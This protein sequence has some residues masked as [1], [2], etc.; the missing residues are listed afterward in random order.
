[1]TAGMGSAGPGASGAALSPA[2]RLAVGFRALEPRT[3]RSVGGRELRLDLHV[4]AGSGGP[5]PTFVFFH[6]G[7]WIIGGRETVSLHLLPW[8]ERGW[9]TVN[10]E[11]RLAREARA[12]AAVWDARHAVR[13]VFEHAGEHGFDTERVVL[14]GFSS[15]GHLALMAGVGGA[16]LPEADGEDARPA[17]IDD[18]AE[19]RVAAVVSWFGISDVAALVEGERPRAFARHWLGARPDFVE[20]AHA[21]SP[22]ERIGPHTPPIL[23]VHGDRDPVV[24]FAQ[25]ERLHRVLDRAGVPNRLHVVPGGGHG[26]WD[27]ETWDRAY[28]AVVGFVEGRRAVGKGRLSTP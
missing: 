12:P 25:S 13:W 7:G 10:V 11:Y 20:L 14:G 17:S 26:D 9:A 4:P 6:G 24:P 16:L 8:M 21:L 5:W 27:V 28:A 19:P 3:Y 18:G 2:V 23:S 22:V 1:M 15:G